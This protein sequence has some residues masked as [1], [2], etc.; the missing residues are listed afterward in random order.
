MNKNVVIIKKLRSSI[1]NNYL[2]LNKQRCT[3]E[4]RVGREEWTLHQQ[5]PKKNVH[6]NTI[7]PKK[8]LTLP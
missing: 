3:Q 1:N 7:K 2:N 8:A 5:F 6:K 4:G